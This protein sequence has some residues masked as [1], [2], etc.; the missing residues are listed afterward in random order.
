M[1]LKKCV[2]L[3]TVIAKARG[4]RGFEGFFFRR[5]SE[6]RARERT[7]RRPLTKRWFEENGTM[8]RPVGRPLAEHV[9]REGAWFHA[10]TGMPY[11]EEAYKVGVRR[12]QAEC[13]RRRYWHTS[14]DTR[15]RRLLRAMREAAAKAPKRSATTQLTLDHLGAGVSH[16]QTAQN[17][18]RSSAVPPRLATEM[19]DGTI[20]AAMLKKLTRNSPNSIY[21]CTHAEGA[22]TLCGQTDAVTLLYER[23]GAAS[24][25]TDK[26]P[27]LA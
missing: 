20:D 9:W 2:I 17:E 16:P 27:R 26:A 15:Q 19:A 5:V 10:A 13:E 7:L 6:P 11:D 14:S 8:S 25:K 24:R 3:A 22:H 18:P 4:R 1:S 12:R 23:N 21:M